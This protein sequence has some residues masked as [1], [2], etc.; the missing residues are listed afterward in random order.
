MKQEPSKRAFAL[1]SFAILCC[2]FAVIL[3]LLA[4]H[5]ATMWVSLVLTLLQAFILGLVSFDKSGTGGKGLF[6]LY[7]KIIVPAICFLAQLI[8]GCLFVFIL[9]GNPLI[10]AVVGIVLLAVSIAAFL[11]LRTTM[12]YAEGI[13]KEARDSTALM[14]ALLLDFQDI[15]SGISSDEELYTEINRVTELLRFSDLRSNA[16]TESIDNSLVKSVG[17]LKNAKL[18][19]M[20][21]LAEIK[22]LVESRNRRLKASK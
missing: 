15:Q 9:P 5:T 4:P 12:S 21:D 11:S 22:R 18:I 6:E 13:E 20:D 1:A 14:R 19:T 17:Q 16:E 7:P 10:P 2:A 3:I 8:V